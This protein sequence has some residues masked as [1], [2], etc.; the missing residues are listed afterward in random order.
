MYFPSF[1]ESLLLIV[2]IRELSVE[3]RL[4]MSSRVIWEAT[5]A[6]AAILLVLV[7][8]AGCD[9]NS[10]TGSANKSRIAGATSAAANAEANNLGSDQS[11]ENESI[12]I[13]QES[14]GQPPVGIG[15]EEPLPLPN[16]EDGTILGEESSEVPIT[17]GTVLTPEDQI[18]QSEDKG[19]LPAADSIVIPPEV[20]D[21]P[22][23]SVEDVGEVPKDSAEDGGGF[24]LVSSGNLEE[25]CKT[26]WQSDFGI[27]C[28]RTA[29][30]YGLPNEGHGKSVIELDPYT[31]SNP[32]IWQKL[33]G[34]IPGQT[35]TLSYDVGA[36]NVATNQGEGL[37]V[38]W[39][40]IKVDEI[41]RSSGLKTAWQTRKVTIEPGDATGGT[42][43]FVGLGPANC[44]GAVID[45]IV[46]K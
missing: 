18:P 16:V 41:T 28:G 13:E 31:C 44:F 29:S 19:E 26:I 12:E 2:P 3:W 4:V 38:L 27:E 20:D 1:F 42:L 9:S 10:F 11:L 17:D 8:N 37:R 23:D 15:K 39:N 25:D 32:K 36:R 33:K 22:K 6:L 24:N 40:G 14:Q 5:I 34:M 30:T 35:Y 7:G 21:V 43:T 45:N 46:V